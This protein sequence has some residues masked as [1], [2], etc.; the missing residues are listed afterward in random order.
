MICHVATSSTVIQDHATSGEWS[1]SRVS[2]SEWIQTV[3]ISSVDTSWQWPCTLVSSFYFLLF[4]AKSNVHFKFEWNRGMKR[5]SSPSL[6]SCDMFCCLSSIQV[7][8][9]NDMCMQWVYQGWPT[10]WD[11]IWNP[12][13]R[14]MW[15]KKLVSQR[16]PLFFS[17]LFKPPHE[18]STCIKVHGL[19][20]C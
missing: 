9:P 2:Q 14:K 4:T 12:D 17:E 10:A 19:V 3:L 20:H 6:E 18:I 16:K 13:D 8:Q 15:R 5:K 1:I 7:K 11:I